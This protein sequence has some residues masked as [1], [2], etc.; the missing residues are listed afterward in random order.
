MKIDIFEVRDFIN[1]TE[2][3]LRGEGGIENGLKAW[4][5]T[6]T[7]AKTT[8]VLVEVSPLGNAIVECNKRYYLCWVCS[9]ISCSYFY[10]NTRRLQ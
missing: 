5:T 2:I 7:I 1:A 9:D 10:S 4:E 6:K 3:E 8:N